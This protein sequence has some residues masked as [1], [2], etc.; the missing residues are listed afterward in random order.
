[1]QR[2]NAVLSGL[3]QLEEDLLK[4]RKREEL[5]KLKACMAG[6]RQMLEANSKR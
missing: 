5:E 3:A 2:V 1:M 6:A 4:K